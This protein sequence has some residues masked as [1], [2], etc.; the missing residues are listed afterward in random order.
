MP[1]TPTHP[2][3]EPLKSAFPAVKFVANSFRDMTTLVVPR[4]SI[5]QVSRFLKDDA[6]TK[7]DFLAELNAVDYL[8]FQGAMGRFAVNYGLSSTT[9]NNRLWL[10]VYLEPTR[11]TAPNAEQLQDEEATTAGDPGL[12]VPSVTSVWAGAEWMEREAYDLMG[13]IFTGHPDLRRIMT[14]N[15]FGSHPLRKD[16]PLRGVGERDDYKIVTRDSA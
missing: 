14:W 11:D 16:Y 1:Q 9:F 5:L 3:F 8:G 6:R 10:R 4:E 12:L 15:G 7:F 2:A 13:V